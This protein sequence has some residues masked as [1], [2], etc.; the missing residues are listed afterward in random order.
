[1]IAARNEGRPRLG[2]RLLRY[3]GQSIA[4]AGHI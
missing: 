3:K 2:P 4:V 1:M